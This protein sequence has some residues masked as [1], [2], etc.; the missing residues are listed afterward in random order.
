[1][2]TEVWC[3]KCSTHGFLKRQ[4]RDHETCPTCDAPLFKRREGSPTPWNHFGAVVRA[5]F[6]F[7]GI[8][9]V[10]GY[11]A[12]VQVPHPVLRVA[13]AVLLFL[14]ATTFAARSAS[15]GVDRHIDFPHINLD[16]L[17]SIKAI[18]AMSIYVVVLVL[19]P[20]ILM[21]SAVASLFASDFLG[22]NAD[23]LPPVP[24]AVGAAVLLVFWAPMALVL[25]LRTRSP[26][27]FFL[28]PH[29]IRLIY[30]DLG[31]YA[32]MASLVIGAQAMLALAYVLNSFVP[33]FLGLGV[34]AVKAFLI[35]GAYGIAG[36]YIRE[37]ARVLDFPVDDDDWVPV[38]E[39][40]DVHFRDVR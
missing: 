33:F 40:V 21:G 5:L 27:G 9:F 38:S 30:H 15:V 18:V 2:T 26:L 19:G 4:P 22:D 11:V 23:L 39:P 3:R 37:H 13:A 20:L 34:T 10:A 14:G 17:L 12:V 1:M 32:A 7:R 24:V 35:L 29:G 25:Y 36:L 31:G 6:S 16:E 28:V 8:L